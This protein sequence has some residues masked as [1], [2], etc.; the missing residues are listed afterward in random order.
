M[1]ETRQKTQKLACSR[2][3]LL[4]VFIHGL[5]VTR[6]SASNA[7]LEFYYNADREVGRELIQ[8]ILC[9]LFVVILKLCNLRSL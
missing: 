6:K 8:S 1:D 2:C 4:I 3:I 5:N 7:T 9:N